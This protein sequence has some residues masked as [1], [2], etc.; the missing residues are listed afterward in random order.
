MDN[1]SPNHYFVEELPGT[2]ANKNYTVTFPANQVEL[3]SEKQV[4]IRKLE[5]RLTEIHYIPDS[6]FRTKTLLFPSWESNILKFSLFFF[7]LFSLKPMFLF[8]LTIP[9]PLPHVVYFSNFR[10]L[11]D[12]PERVFSRRALH[13]ILFVKSTFSAPIDQSFGVGKFVRSTINDFCEE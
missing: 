12:E 11:F 6:N 5:M 13:L 8:S 4:V 10:S 1:A 7:S 3:G 9:P 2:A